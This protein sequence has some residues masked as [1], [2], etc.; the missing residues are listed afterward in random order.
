[1]PAAIQA[2]ARVLPDA[3]V[4]TSLA[5]GSFGV[6]DAVPTPLAPGSFGVDAAVPTSLAPGSFGVDAFVPKSFLYPGSLGEDAANLCRGSWGMPNLSR[7]CVCVNVCVCDFVFFHSLTCHHA[8]HAQVLPLPR[9][10]RGGAQV[11][12][13]PRVFRGG[14]SQ[15]MKR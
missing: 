15:P 2:S 12:P 5:P 1:M 6:E 14:C 7:V 3:A 11:L 10:F 4:P 13:L 9:V 8:S